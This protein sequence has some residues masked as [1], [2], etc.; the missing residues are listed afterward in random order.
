MDVRLPDGTVVKNVPDGTTKADL[1]EKLQRNGMA[2]P[3]EWLQPAAEAP[4]ERKPASTFQQVQASLPGRILQGMRDPVDAGAQLLPRGLSAVA[5]L[6]GMFPNRVSDYLDSEAKRVDKIN[7]TNET[8]YQASRQAVAQPSITGLI[9]GKQADPG[10]DGGRLVGNIISPVNAAVAARLPV[11]T[12]LLGR[13]ATGAGVGALG[14]ALNPVDMSDPDKSFAAAKAAQM[15]LGAL[16]GGIITPVAGKLG[17]MAS[18]WWAGRTVNAAPSAADIEQIARKVVNETGQRWENLEP[19]ARAAMMEQASQ[20]LSASAKG[21]NKAALL[22]KADFDAEGIAPTLGQITRDASQYARERNL[23]TMPGV[24]DGLLQRFEQQGQQ[25]Q[26][27]VGLLSQGA[28][29]PYQAGGLLS[30]ALQAKDESL[31]SGVAS[32]YRAARDAAGKDAEIPM[33]GLAQDVADIFDRYR[34]AVPSGIRGQFAKYGLNPDEVVNQRK[35][36]TVE[37]AD[38]LLKEINKQGSNEPAVISALGELR[39]AV[40]NSITK[41]AGVEDVFSPARRAAAERF[42]L[43][44]AVPAL[45]AA[46]EGTVAP[47]DFVRKFV[48]NGKTDEVKGLAKVLA[49]SSPEAFQQARAQIGAE[50]QKAAFGQNVAGDKA[51]AP[52]RFAEALNKMGSAKLGAFFSAAEI[53]QMHRLSRIG[54]NI[55]SMPNA[56][57]VQTSNNW[58]AI[59]SIASKI[60]GVPASIGLLGSIKN[61]VNNQGDA[62][63]ALAAKVPTEL[64]PE[65]IGILQ[66]LLAG[67]AAAGGLLSGQAVK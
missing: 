60:P 52:D 3:A 10:F 13:A 5:S 45:K 62:A 28:Q 16:T 15:G 22:R 31:R 63:A 64:S 49:E 50:L 61:T 42:K 55:I 39:A 17:D 56:S 20:A 24:G 65:Q 54:A 67:S 33:Q 30:G 46:A 27:K 6:G 44:D 18:K 38:K 36:F 66:H 34:T 40:K 1:V 41:D 8:D 48:I 23:R 35:L 19:A 53:Q 12:S 32:A 2:V 43:H 51:F 57:P 25:L 14:G 29:E 4:Q 58:G 9:T 11:A 26:R 47:D 59:T 37:E 7:A 21:A